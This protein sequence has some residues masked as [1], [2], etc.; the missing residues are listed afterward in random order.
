M[1]RRELLM[2]LGKG[3]VSSA[4]PALV[5]GAGIAGQPRLAKALPPT[6]VL[7]LR[8]Q[9][10]LTVTE[11]AFMVDGA[12]DVDGV[13]RLWWL[14]RD[15]RANVTAPIEV[16]L[17]QRLWWLQESLFLRAPITLLSGYR[18]SKTNEM[19]RARYEGVARKSQHL[20][21]AA[22]DVRFPGVEPE[23]LG[24]VAL[25]LADLMGSGGVGFYDWGCHCDIGDK[26]SW[27]G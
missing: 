4:L 16:E 22:A 14:L 20:R 15:R 9:E 3:L 5:L 11:V 17:F 23:T 19:L 2:T 21:G 18:T 12:Y 13:A 25:L 27:R 1:Q 7:K 24:K 26:R 10:D 6:R 8:H